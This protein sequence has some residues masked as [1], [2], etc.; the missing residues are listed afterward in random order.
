M[1]F[2]TDLKLL[3][4][5]FFTIMLTW[6]WVLDWNWS[7]AFSAHDG[8]A[9]VMPML[10]DLI[11]HRG[12]W[13]EWI[14]RYELVGGAPTHGVFGSLPVMKFLGWLGVHPVLVYN[15][16]V[17]LFQTLHGFFSQRA[18]EALLDQW[19]DFKAKRQWP[20]ILQLGFIWI[21]A[22]TPWLGWRVGYGHLFFL[23]GSL[24]F[25]ASLSFLLTEQ[26]KNQSYTFIIA[27]I[28][29]WIHAFAVGQQMLI[30]SFIFGGP[31]LFAAIW[32]RKVSKLFLVLIGLSLLISSPHWISLYRHHMSSDAARTLFGEEV[33]Y[34]YITAQFLD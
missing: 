28:F 11:Q 34:S 7:H 25:T 1:R 24:L 13:K 21:F 20:W 9:A 22:F 12:N 14:Y 19:G 8:S 2:G 16:L 3:L 18:M 29:S 30:Y 23:Y 32:R 6:F 17:I 27:A 33:T 5:Y 10:I 31:I 4:T 26:N 15:F